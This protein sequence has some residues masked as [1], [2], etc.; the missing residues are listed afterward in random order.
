M[1][2]F[3]K[4]GYFGMAKFMSTRYMF[5]LQIDELVIDKGMVN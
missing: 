5:G 1:A 2:R 3:L 4:E